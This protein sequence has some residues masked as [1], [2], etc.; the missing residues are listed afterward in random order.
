MIFGHYWGDGM[1]DV[2]LTGKLSGQDKTYQTRFAFPG[3]ATDNPEVERLWAYAGIRQAMREI[4]TFGEHPD[5]KQSVVDLAVEYGLVTDYTAMVVMRDEAF[6]EHGIQRTNRDRLEIEQSAAAHRQTRAPVS[7]RA[8][9]QQPMYRSNRPTHS[10]GGAL[11]AWYL[12]LT[13][14]LA[15]LAVR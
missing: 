11:D 2:R 6:A 1:A 9:T 7:R 8:D 14:P 5:L 10:G 12:V 4:D 15:W 13:L 3:S